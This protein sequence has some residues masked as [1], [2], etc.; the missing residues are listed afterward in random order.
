MRVERS[1]HPR[2]CAQ[3]GVGGTENRLVG[4][5]RV[6]VVLFND[7]VN[8][9]EGL[10]AGFNVGVVAARGRGLHA[11]AVNASQQSAHKHRGNQK[12]E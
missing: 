10:E 8:P 2:D 4:I 6:G 9:A 1:Q 5:D 3:G 12:P 11:A 7:V